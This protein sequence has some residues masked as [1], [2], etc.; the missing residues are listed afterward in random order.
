MLWVF[1]FLILFVALLIPILAIVL[2]SP[3]VR[4]MLE[5]RRRP[6]SGQVEELSNR[7]IMLEDQVDEIG[8]ALEQMREETQFLQR[9]IESPEERDPSKKLQ[10]PKQ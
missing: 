8:R 5:S 1:G 10:P 7:V 6:R 2:D 9:L 3:A 4:N